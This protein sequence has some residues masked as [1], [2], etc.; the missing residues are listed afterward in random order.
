MG[1]QYYLH[2]FGV[3]SAVPILMQACV[4]L[5][6]TACQ[7]ISGTEGGQGSLHLRFSDASLPALR[8]LSEQVD[9]NSFLLQI[10]DVQ[11]RKVYDGTYGQAPESFSLPEGAYLVRAASCDFMKPAFSVPE[12]GDEQCVAV[13]AGKTLDVTLECTQLNAGVL[14]HVD[15]SFL[16]AYPSGALV[17]QSDEGSLLYGYREKRIAYFHPGTVRLVLTEDGKD[18]VLMTRE[19]KPRSVLEVNVTAGSSGV[20]GG[21]IRMVVDTSRVWTTENHVIGSGGGREPG[22]DNAGDGSSPLTAF[23]V[24]DA[25]RHPDRENVW[26]RGY[27][28]AGDLTSTN[29]SYYPPFKSKANLLLAPRA[30][31]CSREVCLAVSLPSGAVREGLNLVDHP[32]NIGK[33]VYV[34]GDLVPSYFK[35]TGLKNC[36][37]YKLQ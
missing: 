10:K 31:K 33:P 34:Q 12:Y 6:M 23:T 20:P 24:A 11:G 18:K 13:S 30:G 14:L 37:T 35:L 26:V 7:E 29:A 36:R 32:E 2:Q 1:K 28:V 8:S 17:L 21:G 16:S 9:T 27:I 22:E 3:K 4:A 15:R 25:I 5:T 19:L